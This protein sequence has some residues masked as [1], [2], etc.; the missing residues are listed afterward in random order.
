MAERTAAL[1]GGVALLERAVAFTVGSL[2][3]VTTDRLSSPTPCAG[4]DLRALL[5]HMS[6]SLAAL[7]EAADVGAVDMSRP[8]TPG[9]SLAGSEHP[10][11]CSDD[12]EYAHCEP[13]GDRMCAHCV[14]E[15]LCA[16]SHYLLGAWSRADGPDVVSLDDRH[17]TGSIVAGAGAIEVA[18]HGWDVAAACGQSREIPSALAEEL[19]ELARVIIDGADRPQ[20][21]GLPVDVPAA[22]SDSDRLMAFTGRHPS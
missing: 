9:P 22:A 1:T 2:R 13:S 3:L 6:D 19:L 5:T 18:V 17:L 7:I 16:R 20:R 4:W 10:H 11:C 14:I 15:S 8:V 21:F 12:S